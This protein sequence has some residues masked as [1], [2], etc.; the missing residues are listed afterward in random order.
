M[1][2]NSIKLRIIYASKKFQQ[3][4]SIHI[5]SKVYDS[6]ITLDAIADQISSP[7]NSNIIEN[8]FNIKGKQIIPRL[9]IPPA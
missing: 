1:N 9:K 4:N 3:K 7:D 8:Q 2:Q 6:L 5:N